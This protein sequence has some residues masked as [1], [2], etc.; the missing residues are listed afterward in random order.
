MRNSN[1]QTKNKVDTWRIY[2]FL[3]IVGS[4]LVIFVIRLFN[5]QIVQGPSWELEAE[6]NRTEDRFGPQ[7]RVL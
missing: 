2:G 1:N 6:E 5:L 3:I 7:Y 4:V